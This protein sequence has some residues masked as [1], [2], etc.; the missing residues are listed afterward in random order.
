MWTVRQDILDAAK[1]HNVVIKE[2]DYESGNKLRMDIAKKYTGGIRYKSFLW[3]H[4]IDSAHA[5]QAESWMWIDDFL[6]NN[7]T[8]L[9]FNEGEGDEKT[10]FEITKGEEIIKILSEANYFEFN[11]TDY[12]TSYL[13]CYSHHQ[14]LSA[15]GEAKEWLQSRINQI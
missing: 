12:S 13:I 15:A 5:G 2:L 14:T 11:L 1:K 7:K 9:F 6:K 10:I 3:D 8:I 4:L